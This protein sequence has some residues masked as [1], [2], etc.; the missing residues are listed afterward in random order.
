MGIYGNATGG[1][2]MPKTLVLVDENNNELTGVV[3]D[4]VAVF[5]ATLNDIRA[6]KV[7]ANAEGVV[8]GTKEIPSYNT[9]EGRKLIPAGSQCTLYI[10]DYDYTRLQAMI[11]TYNTTLDD[12]VAAEKVIVNDNVYDV[13]STTSIAVVQKDD[14]NSCIHFGFINTSDQPCVIRY[15]SYKEML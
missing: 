13:R 6:G 14:A 8:T 15:F 3:V 5:D 1:F 12:S 9:T 7:A 2:G 4:D 11:C 10:T